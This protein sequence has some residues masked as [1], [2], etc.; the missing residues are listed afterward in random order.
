MK[1]IKNILD[2][3]REL[4]S[5]DVWNRLNARLDA[6]MPVQGKP[7]HGILGKAWKW[8]AAVVA[9]AVV[10]SA[11]F[12]AVSVNLLGHRYKPHT[13]ELS[14]TEQQIEKAE[15][16]HEDVVTVEDNTEPV[17]A[18]NSSENPSTVKAVTSAESN[19]QK[20]VAARNRHQDVA[21]QE[22]HETVA[23]TT[24][25]PNVPHEV[26]PANSTL[27][28]QLAADPI[29]KTISPEA[30]DWTMPIHLSIPNLFTPNN[31][32][33]NDF[34]VIEGIENYTTPRLVI[35]DKSGRV[36]YQHNHYPNNWGGENCPD[37]VY[38]YEFNFTYNGI[39]NQA[40]GK[41]RIMRN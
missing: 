19:T 24:Y 3:N 30:V 32:G 4:P 39:E 25:K 33:V 16:T 12:V 37:G 8:A 7:S 17:L 15:T 1:D 28:K 18:D 13:T 14:D 34:F 29:L 27:A 6:E 26:I 2:N 40:T 36:V 9:T 10:G 35:R 20:D 41:V 11:I 22:S 31:D 38:N 23:K 21:D 5:E